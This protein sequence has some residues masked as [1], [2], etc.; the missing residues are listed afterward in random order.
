MSI[1][2][3]YFHSIFNIIP[4]FQ[5]RETLSDMRCVPVVETTAIFMIKNNKKSAQSAKSAS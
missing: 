3:F 2:K 1:F 5:P 4:W